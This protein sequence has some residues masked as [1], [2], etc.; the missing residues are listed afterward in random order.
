MAYEVL[1]DYTKA[2]LGISDSEI[3][4]SRKFHILMLTYDMVNN[5]PHSCD[6]SESQSRMDRFFF[7]VF[8]RTKCRLPKSE[9]EAITKYVNYVKRKKTKGS[10]KA[11]LS[12]LKDEVTDPAF[13]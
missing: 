9:Q 11:V 4:M 7:Y 3:N 5:R 6:R 8:G 2:K 1:K 13:A 10:V 12:E